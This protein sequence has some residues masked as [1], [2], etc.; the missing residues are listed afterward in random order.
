MCSDRAAGW[1]LGPTYF[2]LG[3]WWG[4]CALNSLVRWSHR[5]C[6]ADG[7]SHQL[8]SL[9]E[10]HTW[11]HWIGCAASA[12]LW[13]RSSVE[14]AEA[15]I[16]LWVGLGFRF[17]VLGEA[18]LKPVKIFV[19]C[20]NCNS[21][22]PTL[23]VSG[24]NRATGFAQQTISSTHSPLGL[25]LILHRLQTLSLALLLGGPEDTLHHRGGF[26][27]LHRNRQPGL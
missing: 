18:A 17:S 5:F 1:K 25:V 15:C 13:V 3:T 26:S 27:S 16:Q 4:Q 9:C 19:C 8:A 22:Q 23:Q 10:C 7:G 6:S 12:M 20:L 11:G 14:Q 2:C 24:L 21:S